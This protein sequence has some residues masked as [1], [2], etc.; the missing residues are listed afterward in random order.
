MK[1]GYARV[2]T[3][4]QNLG[5]QQA[6]LKRDGCT[7]VF[8]ETRSGSSRKCPQLA[9]AIERLKPGDT[10]TV[11]KID[12]I[13]RNLGH[14]VEIIRELKL[15]EVHLR[16]ISEGIDI[17]TSIGKFT[18]YLLGAIAELEFDNIAERTE[19]GMQFAKQSGRPL[20]RRSSMTKRQVERARLLAAKDVSP[21]QIA[22]MMDVGRTTIYRALSIDY[23]P[24]RALKPKA[25]RAQV[26]V[27]R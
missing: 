13:S 20:G 22:E 6:M 12:R 8:S 7:R 5:A 15:R 21:D 27:Q 19:G 11:F 3:K 25:R 1:I 16:S 4:K 24:R 26:A 18:A 9:R 17:G 14:L 23:I 10:L 2:S